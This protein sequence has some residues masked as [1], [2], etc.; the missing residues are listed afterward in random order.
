MWRI[1]TAIVVSLFCSVTRAEFLIV[2][3]AA[4]LTNAMTDIG[5]LFEAQNPGYNIRFNFAGSGTLVQQI[6]KGAPADVLATADA[7]SMNRAATSS[8]IETSTRSNFVTNHLVLITPSTTTLS[9]NQLQDLAQPQVTRF[10]IGNPDSVP[11]G[12]YAK[13]VLEA[14][15][16]WVALSPKAIYAQNVRQASLYV[17]QNEVN[18]GIVFSTDAALAGEA[19]KI[20]LALKTTEPILYPVAMV[21]DTA[22]PA[23][24]KRFIQFLMEPPAQAVFKRYGFSAPPL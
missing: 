16:L 15:N 12:L 23:L 11:A 5:S 1:I 10:T 18:A 4:S 13:Q 8:L 24:A 22:R 21:K 7:H 19:V 9:I 20:V 14:E 17:A 3:A 6:S 2:S